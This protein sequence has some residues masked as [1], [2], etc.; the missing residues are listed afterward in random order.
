MKVFAWVG[1]LILLAACAQAPA[2]QA[3]GAA[4][5][6]AA[7]IEATPA[8][9]GNGMGHRMGMGRSSGM[10]TRHHA[11]IPAEYAGLSNPVPAGEESYDRAAAIYASQCAS[12]HGD[13]GMG[14]GPAGSALDPAPAPIAHTSQM[15]GVDYLFWRISEGGTTFTTSMPGW[16]DSLDETTRWDLVNYI[17]ALGTGAVQPQQGTGGEAYDPA[18]QAAEQ[19]TMLEE[20]VSSGVITQEE[21]DLFAR[22]HDALD[23][24]RQQNPSAL[25]VGDDATERQAAMLKALVESGKI[26][27]A[28]ADAFVSIHDRLGEA[29]VMP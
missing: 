14:D 2:A 19:A 28:E 24:Y 21:A 7:P 23:A 15:M 5:I 20:A 27:Q 8:D 18:A 9:N 4:P 13:G 12:C 25:T 11:Q 3:P 26:T 17:Q 16:K 1:V 29:G 22:V 10:M 6:E